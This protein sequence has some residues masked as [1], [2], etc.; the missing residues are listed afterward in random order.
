MVL[1][2]IRRCE[3][4]KPRPEAGG[5]AMNGFFCMGRGC[6]NA[7]V[8]HLTAFSGGSTIYFFKNNMLWRFAF[9]WLG[10]YASG[11]GF[12]LGLLGTSVH[13]R[14]FQIG[15]E[16]TLYGVYYSAIHRIASRDYSQEQINAWAPAEVD[17]ILWEEKIQRIN[18]F[19]AV[20]DG[21]VVGYTDIQPSG[22]IDHFF[23]SGNRPRQGIGAN[24]MGVI[25]QEAAQRGITE[26]TSDVSLT[27]QPFFS[28]FGFHVVE[29]RFPKRRGVVIPNALMRKILACST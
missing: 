23:V 24:L 28:K 11:L 21:V 22:Y 9:F 26:L 8:R 18:P 25:H 7:T 1:W 10:I 12:I 13:I 17:Q 14:R 19:V 5:G 3:A 16:A 4:S 15:E 29:H 20:I 27:A 2:V 6:T